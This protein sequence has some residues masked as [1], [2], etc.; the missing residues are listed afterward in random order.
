ME[1]IAHIW[2]TMASLAVDLGKPYQT[3]AAWK[4]RGRIPA[5]YDLDLIEAAKRRGHKLTLSALAEARRAA[6]VS[7]DH[8]PSNGRT[9]AP[10]QGAAK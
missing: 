6:V 5:D 2:P 8:P 10:V 1:H 9:P 3:V 7:G 4:L